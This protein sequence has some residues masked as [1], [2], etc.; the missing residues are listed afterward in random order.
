MFVGPD[1]GLC[2]D[3]KWNLQMKNVGSNT[4]Q[5]KGAGRTDEGIF[6]G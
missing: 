1:C 2:K 3:T 4:E 5:L 6:A